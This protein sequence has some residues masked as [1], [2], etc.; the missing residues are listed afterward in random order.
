MSE[1]QQR[2]PLRPLLD[3]IRTA[4]EVVESHR[5][6]LI[7]RIGQLRAMADDREAEAMTLERMGRDVAA[8]RAEVV[9]LNEQAQMLAGRVNQLMAELYGVPGVTPQTAPEVRKAWQRPEWWQQLHVVADALHKM[10]RASDIYSEKVGLVCREQ[11]N[12]SMARVAR[13]LD[14]KPEDPRSATIENVSALRD[15]AERIAPIPWNLLDIDPQSGAQLVLTIRHLCK[16]MPERE[17]PD[18]REECARR[19]DTLLDSMQGH[20]EAGRLE[21]ARQHLKDGNVSLA[22]SIVSGITPPNALRYELNQ[23]ALLISE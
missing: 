13:V 11:I 18:L 14:S 20:K 4:N 16:D 10:E 6:N 17:T 21:T 5:R 3:E 23:L 9:R 12:L 1:P 8:Q 15:V 19:F 2:P 7:E 22:Y